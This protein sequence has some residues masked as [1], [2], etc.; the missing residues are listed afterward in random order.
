MDV[1]KPSDR[2]AKDTVILVTSLC[3]VFVGGMMVAANCVERLNRLVVGNI[4]E[5]IL[6]LVLLVLW[7]SSVIFLHNPNNEIATSMSFGGE[8]IINFANLYFAGWCSFFSSMYVLASIFSD[9]ESFDPKLKNWFLLFTT[10]MILLGTSSYI[11]DEVCAERPQIICDRDKFAIAIGAIIS[12]LSVV[13]IL[14]LT[15]M[16][17]PQA[18][19][20]F[21]LSGVAST[22]Y[23]LCV[24]LLTSASGPAQEI[25]TQYFASWAGIAFSFSLFVDSFGELFLTEDDVNE[26]L[27]LGLPRVGSPTEDND[28]I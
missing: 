22:A 25:G 2:S 14:C 23:I 16:K 27:K 24:I 7:L 5:V 28:D 19:V 11:K 18:L 10:S 9:K 8:E 13:A 17:K 6:A 1:R 26:A 21:V 12:F 4:C 15:C 20:D 3:S